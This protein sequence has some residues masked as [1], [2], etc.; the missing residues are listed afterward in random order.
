[1]IKLRRLKILGVALALSAAAAILGAVSLVAC[2]LPS[3][4]A[5]KVSAVEALAEQ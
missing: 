1:M 5:A 2:V 3:H 4:R